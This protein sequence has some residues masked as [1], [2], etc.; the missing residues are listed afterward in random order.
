MSIIILSIV[1]QVFAVIS[2]LL[3]HKDICPFS[4]T[5][6]EWFYYWA[7]MLSCVNLMILSTQYD[8]IAAITLS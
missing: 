1:I 7:C 3:S 8:T 4:L 5:V 6:R 2:M